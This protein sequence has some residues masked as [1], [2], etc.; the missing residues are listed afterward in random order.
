MDDHR[1]PHNQNPMSDQ[2]GSA[3]QKIEQNDLTHILNTID[4]ALIILDQDLRITHF[5]HQGADLFNC[6][7]RDIGRKITDLQPNI[8]MEHLSSLIERSVHQHKDLTEEQEDASGILYLIKIK[9]VFCSDGALRQI[10]LHGQK[11]QQVKKSRQKLRLHS[12]LLNAIKDAVIVFDDQEKIIYFNREAEKQY[13]TSVNEALGQRLSDIYTYLFLSVE[14]QQQAE[15][16]LRTQGFWRGENIHITRTGR[17]YHVEST[18]TTVKDEKGRVIGTQAIIH[19]MTARK[20][21]EMVMKENQERLD[22]AMTA[23]RMFA[24]EWNSQTD[25]VIRSPQCQDILGVG[26]DRLRTKAKPY[27]KSVHPDDKEK[28]QSMLKGLTPEQNTYALSYRVKR[29]DSQAY[30][31]LGEKGQ[32]YFDKKGRLRRIFGLAA[33]ITERKKAE[34]SIKRNEQIFRALAESNLIGV[35]FGDSQG[36]MSYVNDEMLRMMGYTRQDYEPGRINWAQCVAPEYRQELAEWKERLNRDGRIS[37]YERAFVKPNGERTP[38]LGAAALVDPDKDFHV[39]VA[40]DLSKLYAAERAV[41]ESEERFRRAIEEAPIPVIMH[42]EDGEVLQI[43]RSWAELT[44]YTMRD[45]P[46]FNTWTDSAIYGSGAANV[47]DFLKSLFS[48]KIGKRVKKEFMVCTKT[49]KIRYWSFSASMPGR[50]SDGRRF[51][52]GMAEDVTARKAYEEEIRQK[53]EDLQRAQAVGRIGSWRL[54]IPQ[55]KL[56]WS[57]ENHRIFGVPKG[58]ELTYETFLS[59]V[60]P[61]DRRY[62]D[63]QWKAA[64]NGESY[65]VEHRIITHGEVKWVHER[66]YLEFDAN[67]NLITGF[68]ISQDITER[69][70]LENQIMQLSLF[71]RQ[72]PAPVMRVSMDQYVMLFSNEAGTQFLQEWEIDIGQRLPSQVVSLLKKAL[73]RKSL[74]ELELPLE[75]RVFLFTCIFLKKE[76]YINLYGSD[77]TQ[78]KKAE[79][80]LQRDKETLEKMVQERTNDLIKAELALEQKKRLSDIGTLAATVA[81]ELRNPLA[82]ISMAAYNIDRKNKNASILPNLESIQAKVVDSEKIIS[83]LLFYSR[84]KAPEFQDVCLFDIIKDCNEHVH[85]YSQKKNTVNYKNMEVIRTQ[86]ICADSLQMKELFL[87]IFNNAYDAIDEHM[88]LITVNAGMNNGLLSVSIHDNGKGIDQ[89]DLERICNPFFTTK[90]KGTGLGLAV[91]QQIVKFHNGTLKIQSPD[92]RGTEV[93]ISLPVSRKNRR[94]D[95]EKNFDLG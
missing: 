26:E 80:V 79:V 69:K 3:S 11:I 40:L 5:N 89:E 28:F 48:R 17:R 70:H 31:I 33:D 68:G 42:A 7:D 16:C 86:C 87:N 36:N 92:G 30:V 35:G 56:S 81:H 55:N 24:F 21:M 84:L 37:G 4:L 39:S 73:A 34:E 76:R 15:I 10:F 1:M 82:A 77:V 22:A 13:E 60:H 49:G 20:G 65:N 95:E 62:V 38:Y 63:Q 67:N 8:L 93:M 78:L 46:S 66:A 12:S 27:F 71:P 57:D 47:R 43:S 53:R 54:N 94:K 88:G 25:A 6:W 90:A 74:A 52:V 83:N 58:E 64:L 19:D 45:I 9:P 72:N 50:L 2:K 44:G 51:I 75:N 18:V 91:C 59:C 85:H 14:D 23:G 41:Y 32:A 61:D 29:E